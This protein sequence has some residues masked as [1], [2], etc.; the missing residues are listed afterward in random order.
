MVFAT[1]QLIGNAC[2]SMLQAS[3]A[4]ISI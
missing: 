2:S 1:F 4:T 3:L